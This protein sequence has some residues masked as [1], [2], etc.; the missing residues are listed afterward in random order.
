MEQR[1]NVLKE[2]HAKL[3]SEKESLDKEN[4][5]LRHDATTAKAKVHSLESELMQRDAEAERRKMDGDNILRDRNA[6]QRLVEEKQSDIESLQ[7]RLQAAGEKL[8]SLTKAN[9]DLDAQFHAAQASQT[10]AAL[11][12]TRIEQEKAILEKGNKWLYEELERK[13]KAISEERSKATKSILDLQSQLNQVE[14]EFEKLKGDHEAL[15]GRFEAQKKSAEEVDVK[16]REARE[17]LATK[18]AAFEK[19]LAMANRMAQLYRESADERGKRCAELEGIVQELNQHIENAAVAHKEAL[20]RA[21]D[22][23]KAAENRA[24]EEKALRE[25]VVAA[26]ASTSLP[27]F[28]SP[29]T[30]SPQPG[31]ASPSIS[32]NATELYSKYIE[33]QQ[34]WQDE[35][36]KNRQREIVMNELL[37][38]VERRAEA[39]KEQQVEYE[40]IKNAYSQVSVDVESMSAEKRRLES[41]LND[42]NSALRRNERER[43]S[44]EQQVKD[45]GLQI[46]RLLH[47]S[48]KL[49]ARTVTGAVSSDSTPK[50]FSGGNAKD[51]TTQLLVEFK[52]IQEL[53][54]QNQRLLR[55]NREL[56]EAAEAT[57][58]EAEEDLRREYEGQLDQL[59]AEFEELKRGRKQAEQ[60][61]SQVMKQRDTLRQLLQGTEG[62]L[63]K[64]K[65]LYA[66]SIDGKEHT[67]PNEQSVLG[68]QG[69]ESISQEILKESENHNYRELYT[70]LNSQYKEYKEESAKNQS[71]L[72]AE[73][74]RAKEDA[75]TAKSE[76]ARSNATA[77]F[78]RERASRLNA[79]L[80][81]QRQ[82][83]DN[84][85]ASNAKYQALITETERQLHSAQSEA[86]A[87]SDDLRMAKVK[88]ESLESEKRLL[89]ETEKRI[90]DELSEVSKEKFKIA[91]ELEAARILHSERE[92]VLSAESRRAR[93]DAVKAAQELADA[94]RELSVAK[95]RADMATRA[96]EHAENQA[97]EKISRL[98]EEL[99][100]TRD[101]L[102]TSQQRASAAEAKVD[103]LKD[104]IQKAEEKVARLEI[105]RSTRV[106]KEPQQ[107]LSAIASTYS[108]DPKSRESELNAEIK[109]LREELVAAQESAASAKG[110]A[111]QFELL[112]RTAEEALKSVQQDH[113]KFKRESATRI[114][115]MENEITV[116]RETVLEKEN[117]LRDAKQA[118]EEF[119]AECERLDRKHAEQHNNLKS[120]LD[121]AHADRE[122][123]KEKVK[124]LKQDMENLCRELEDTKRMYEA[125]VMSHGDALRR[126]SS[127]DSAL[128]A[129]QE[130]LNLILQELDSERSN[131]Q[132]LESELREQIITLEGKLIE[133]NQQVKSLGE[134]RSALQDQLEK[135]ASGSSGE[136]DFSETIRLLRRE[137]EAVEI[138]L[139]LAERDNARL[140][141]E[142]TVAKRAAEEARAQL[143]AE[144]ERQRASVRDEAKHGELLQKVEQFNLLRESNAAL[145]ADNTRAQKQVQEIQQKLRQSES[146]LLP[147]QQRIR[148]LEASEE[149]ANAELCAA[150]EESERWQ[151]RAQQLMQKYESVDAVE[152]QRVSV[153]L[154]KSQEAV[155][156][157]EE[158]VSER[159]KEID[160]L[161]QSLLSAEKELKESHKENNDEAAK[162]KE[163]LEAKKIESENHRKRAL[164]IWSAVVSTCNKEK[165]PLQEWKRLQLEKEKRFAELEEKF[166][167]GDLRSEET[168]GEELAS[169]RARVAQLEADLIAAQEEIKNAKKSAIEF[170][171]RS[172]AS[173][174]IVESQLEEAKRQLTVSQETEKSALMKLE[175]LQR[176]KNSL[177]EKIKTLEQEVNACQEQ[178][179]IAKQPQRD[180]ADGAVAQKHIDGRADTEKVAL[181]RKHEPISPQSQEKDDNLGGS[182]LFESTEQNQKIK[183]QKLRP[184]ATSFTPQNEVLAQP[185]LIVDDE[186]TW[187]Q[188]EE[189]DGNEEVGKELV[190]QEYQQE[191]GEVD[192][193][194]EEEHIELEMGDK[195]QHYHEEESKDGQ[196]RRLEEEQDERAAEHEEEHAEELYEVEEDEDDN[197]GE[198]DHQHEGKEIHLEEEGGEYDEDTY[199]EE[200]EVMPTQEEERELNEIEA[201]EE[202]IEEEGAIETQDQQDEKEHHKVEE[203]DGG[204]EEED[205]QAMEEEEEQHDNLA[206]EESI[207]EKSLEKQV[208]KQE[209]LDEMEKIEK[210]EKVQEKASIKQQVSSSPEK[211]QQDK[212]KGKTK[213]RAPIAWVPPPP[214]APKSGPVKGS[215]NTQTMGEPEMPRTM[216]NP[217]TTFG[218]QTQYGI[219]TPLGMPPSRG[220]GRSMGRAGTRGRSRGRGRN[221]PPPPPQPP[222]N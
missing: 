40:R 60:I 140:R 134:Q 87:A 75:S 70:E 142:A 143:G 32:P 186:A 207:Q 210:T 121:Q 41:S 167:S 36:L 95:S 170:G 138:N 221:Q 179:K 108:E 212:G 113:D 146:Q 12:Q 50:Q 23:Q 205:I 213:R 206:P 154:K 65:I 19:E 44:L 102:A 46:A 152:Y 97:T 31:S 101:D 61:L 14:G 51:V 16:L 129:S 165:K 5:A 24:E 11:N 137:R 55:V 202:R 74:S 128:K 76:A 63:S 199:D 94:Q 77:E 203:N 112:A 58:A 125:E 82:Q 133:S 33:M 159:E 45:L 92:E 69:T 15:S 67:E 153:E 115:A 147:L 30:L 123:D 28:A 126:L 174:K 151:K 4:Q 120:A 215:K 83:L 111:K 196:E 118:E 182:E 117:A 218:T 187:E 130:R 105:E 26:A 192:E 107:T 183:K 209:Q 145:R 168:K 208:K 18:A 78:E 114:D 158:K 176:D 22:A 148:E 116:L 141:Q 81:S 8:V 162:L 180:S 91:A 103:M 214:S 53:Q 131:K 17:E 217:A 37:A 57:K 66:R 136:G 195:T 172:A 124:Q 52:D 106:P 166:K 34:K 35:K 2:A 127:A 88:V 175:V 93:E 122:Q 27:S 96:A 68:E 188:P 149:S 132:R 99:R 3:A 110:H 39:I 119:A 219:A 155:R 29:T 150:R 164:A 98:E 86:Q 173:R 54:Q 7:I 171:K 100:K 157:A 189:E 194:E 1:Y 71:M 21:E 135:A 216:T 197:L 181:K 84:L 80:D 139:Q 204:V 13:N 56:S 62:D 184:T 109:L 211:E 64:A 201:D 191:D 200:H 156:M 85:M 43:K 161:K 42:A 47:E 193:V 6:L 178:L 169:L 38:E 90:A 220:G 163:E 59:A 89:K 10:R 144:L 177:T 9:T 20:D 72:S 160:T 25:R 222:Q 73:L 48:Q 190:D 49:T 104:A 79:S 198:E 185:E